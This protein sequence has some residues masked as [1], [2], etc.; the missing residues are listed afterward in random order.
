VYVHV[1][2]HHILLT[3]QILNMKKNY[4]LFLLLALAACKKGNQ[5]PKKSDT[6]KVVVPT[7]L[8]FAGYTW[9]ITNSNNATQGPGPNVFDPNFA[10][11][12]DDGFL[13]L[14][15]AKSPVDNKFHCAEVTLA[16]NLGYGTYQ[17]EVD[18]RL[19]S[20][21]K[22][23]VFGLFNYS[24]N[25]GY[26][27][28]DIEY[29]KWGYPDNNKTLGYTIFPAVGSSQTSTEVDFPFTLSGSYTTQRFTRTVD[30]VVCKSLG[31]FHDDDSNLYASHTFT[32]PPTSISTLSMP[33]LMNLWLFK[34]VAPPDGYSVEIVIHSFKF[35]PQ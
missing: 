1:I 20:L 31:G 5:A 6:T 15:L 29:S 24:G 9:N 8:S 33:I 14:K 18:G 28:M 35:T 34:G 17:W 16:Q 19:D 22:N 21:D 23:V 3:T 11:V 4:L 26:D 30:S 27:E 13:H 10:W 2:V 32:N 12:D 7:T 25:D